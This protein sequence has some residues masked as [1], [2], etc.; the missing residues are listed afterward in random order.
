LGT[1]QDGAYLYSKNQWP[2][3]HTEKHGLYTHD[4]IVFR[5]FSWLFYWS[6]IER[7]T[8]RKAARLQEEGDTR[9]PVKKPAWAV[10]DYKDAGGRVTHGAVTEEVEHQKQALKAMR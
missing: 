1:D 3:K 2:R 7:K 9:E 5:V 4:F 6:F 8:H 10:H